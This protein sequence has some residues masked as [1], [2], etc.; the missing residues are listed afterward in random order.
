MPFQRYVN[1]VFSI[2]NFLT[3]IVNYIPGYD[4]K[5]GPMKPRFVVLITICG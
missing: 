1:Y 4:Y 2:L 3:I 5:Q